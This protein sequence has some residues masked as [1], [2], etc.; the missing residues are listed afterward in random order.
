V[1]RKFRWNVGHEP[2]ANHTKRRPNTIVKN[3]QRRRD[4]CCTGSGRPVGTGLITSCI[5]QSPVTKRLKCGRTPSITFDATT[6]SATIQRTRAI[7]VRTR[8]FPKLRRVCAA[9]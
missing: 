6:P 4:S 8:T 3:F 7:N 2:D 5:N 1:I 9:V